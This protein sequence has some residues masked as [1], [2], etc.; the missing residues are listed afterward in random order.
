MCMQRRVAAANATA[1]AEA[2]QPPKARKP[3]TAVAGKRGAARGRP[4]A[5]KERRDA[6]LEVGHKRV[7]MLGPAREL[8]L[9]GLLLPVMQSLQSSTA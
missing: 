3:A 6:A 8:Y 7:K 4:P 5:P 9:L 1:A 2:P